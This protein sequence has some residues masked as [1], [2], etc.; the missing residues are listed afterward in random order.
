MKKLLKFMNI[1]LIITVIVLAINDVYSANTTLGN[2]LNTGILDNVT[3]DDQTLVNKFDSPINKVFGTIMTICQILGV[4]GIV[5]NGVR[6][7]YASSNDKAKIK[8]SLIYV[9]IGT[10]FIFATNIV[11]KIITSGWGDIS[12]G[13]T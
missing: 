13:L 4:A 10:I 8:Q 12:N 3:K 11:V 1:V 7:M 9:V 6:Y 2:G 5:V